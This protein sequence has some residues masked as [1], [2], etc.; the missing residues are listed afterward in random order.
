MYVQSPE[1]VVAVYKDGARALQGIAAEI[2]DFSQR[3]L[4]DGAATFDQMT[5]S[6]SV[7]QLME[8]M[9]A[10]SKRAMEE[11]AEQMS[12]IASMYASA[13]GDQTRAVQSLVVQGHRT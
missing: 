10:Y 8:L 12:R 2:T 11:N 1:H 6:Q 3:R 13:V 4:A 7:P 5:R 9:L